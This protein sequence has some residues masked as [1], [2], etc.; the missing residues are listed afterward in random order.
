MGFVIPLDGTCDTFTSVIPLD[1]ILWYLYIGDPFGWDF[2]IHL[3]VCGLDLSCYLVK[4]SL[5]INFNN[6]LN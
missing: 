3:P 2:V 1:G 4:L 6:S 5:E